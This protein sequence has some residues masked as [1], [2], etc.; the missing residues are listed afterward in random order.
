MEPA[1]ALE[2]WQAAFMCLV[3]VLWCSLADM[4]LTRCVGG[5]GVSVLLTAPRIEAIGHPSWPT[6]GTAPPHSLRPRHRAGAAGL[7]WLQLS[8]PEMSLSISSQE[9]WV[10]PG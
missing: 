4:C 1:E 9:G 5:W 7:S 2:G 3:R 8:S 10:E 6:L